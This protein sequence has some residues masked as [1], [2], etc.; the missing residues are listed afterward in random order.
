MQCSEVLICC[1]NVNKK[2]REQLVIFC[3]STTSRPE[4]NSIKRD[5]L[6]WNAAEKTGY[7]N[8][9]TLMSAVSKRLREASLPAQP[10]FK[11]RR[12]F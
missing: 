7:G 11:A 6:I 4:S 2:A 9:P 1:T 12:L 8:D 5:A 3:E 10:M